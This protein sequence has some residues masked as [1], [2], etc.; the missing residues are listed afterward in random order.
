V[1]AQY[2]KDGS[3]G[4]V[5][6]STTPGT[7]MDVFANYNGFSADVL[8]EKKLGEAG[9]VDLEGA[10]YVFNG[11]YELVENQFYGLISYLTPAEVGI[12]RLQPLVRFQGASPKG[13]GDMWQMLDAQVGYVM[14]EYAARLALGYQ[15]TKYSAGPDITK[16]NSIFLGLQLQ[17]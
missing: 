11:D 1:S 3:K 14:N 16:G 17:K 12:G 5:P 13:G 9:T 7:T 6:S 10:Y 8:F 4:S 2:K 15:Y